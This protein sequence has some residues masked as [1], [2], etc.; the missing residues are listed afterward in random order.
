MLYL[1]VCVSPSWNCSLFFNNF[2]LQRL[3][4]RPARRR[5]NPAKAKAKGLLKRKPVH[6]VDVSR[7][8][9]TFVNWLL[10]PLTVITV[11][12]TLSL[13]MVHVAADTTLK[14]LMVYQELSTIL[15]LKIRHFL[16][17]AVKLILMMLVALDFWFNGNNL[18]SQ[19]NT[20]WISLCKLSWGDENKGTKEQRKQR[21]VGD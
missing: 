16:K 14:W 13:I 2:S 21:E 4:L 20:K 7:S 10:V 8:R 5:G 12:L 19:Q 18:K 6:N 3:L 11:R 9:I 17:C 15:S 1:I